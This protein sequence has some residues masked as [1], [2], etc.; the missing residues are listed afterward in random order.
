ME[1]ILYLDAAN[2]F[3]FALEFL[4]VLKCYE[5]PLPRWY[6]TPSCPSIR[7]A[8][9]V[10]TDISG[11][12]YHVA[13]EEVLPT[14]CDAL[15]AQMP[16]GWQDGGTFAFTV[17]PVDML[18]RGSEGH[19]VGALYEDGAFVEQVNEIEGHS[20]QG[21]TSCRSWCSFMFH[22]WLGTTE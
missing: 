15:T 1:N 16:P 14:L 13:V 4:M 2:M 20:T 6:S 21:G 5:M 12:K 18:L 7:L 22:L 8:E 9:I 17:C 19:R 3:F 10:V 11:K